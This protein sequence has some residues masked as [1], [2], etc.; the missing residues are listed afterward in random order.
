MLQQG[1]ATFC[2]QRLCDNLTPNSKRLG[3]KGFRVQVNGDVYSRMLILK[4]P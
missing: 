2:P 3:V 1:R 4:H